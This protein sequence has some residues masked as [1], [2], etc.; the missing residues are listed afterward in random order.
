MIEFVKKVFSVFIITLIFTQA[1]S[2]PFKKDDLIVKP[3][4]LYYFKS[5][6]LPFTG[7]ISGPYI[8]S[9][10]EYQKQHFIKRYIEGKIINGKRE[11]IW[12]TY[13]EKG[14]LLFKTFCENGSHNG[15]WETFYENGNIKLKG[16][17]KN[18]KL[19]GVWQSYSENGVLIDKV[20]YN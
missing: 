16:S 6:E 11:G 17:Y 3:N 1:L 13:S 20:K 9:I 18:S 14:N 7:Y 19:F 4:G 8:E 12:L 10:T 5:K 15:I 2:K